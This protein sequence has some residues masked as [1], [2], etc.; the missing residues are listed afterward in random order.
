MGIVG[1]HFPEMVVSAEGAKNLKRMSIQLSKPN[2]TF[3][4]AMTI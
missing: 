3:L 1:P 4:F 2:A